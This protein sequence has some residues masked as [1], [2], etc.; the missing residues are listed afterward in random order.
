MSDQ[1]GSP[2]DILLVD[3]DPGD[4][5]LTKRAFTGSKHQHVVNA[6]PD[7]AEALKFLRREGEYSK[8]KRP[9]LILL[10]LNMPRLDGRETLAQI[11]ADDNL[12]TIPVVVLTTSDADQDIRQSYELQASCYVTKPVDF[13]QFTRV[14]QALQEFWFCAVKFPPR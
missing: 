14:V 5:L 13:E 8:A 3:D 4:V 10:D 12:K 9:D 6:V 2:I 11:K 7:G 1:N